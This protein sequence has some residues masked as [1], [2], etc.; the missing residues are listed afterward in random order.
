MACCLSKN[1][2]KLSELSLS[3]SIP[4]GGIFGPAPN[5]DFTVALLGDDDDD[6]DDDDEGEEDAADATTLSSSSESLFD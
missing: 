6:D 3:P 4:K 5:E 2:A 1:N